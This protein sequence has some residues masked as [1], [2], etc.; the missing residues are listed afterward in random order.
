MKLPFIPSRK[1]TMEELEEQKE[2][3]VIEEEILTKQAESEERRAVIAELKKK[4]G[5]GWMKILG[6]S[7]LTD[8]TT[9]RSFLKGAKKGLEGEA[10]KNSLNKFYSLQ[11]ITRA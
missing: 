5:G 4:Y 10:S 9:L 6:V 3:A 1:P 11:G 2:R 8:L 7:K